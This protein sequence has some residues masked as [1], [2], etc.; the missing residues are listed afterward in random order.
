MRKT[1]SRPTHKAGARRSAHLT[2][3]PLNYD[4]LDR[5]DGQSL[6]CHFCD[7]AR[8]SNI[9]M[10]LVREVARRLEQVLGPGGLPADRALRITRRP[11]RPD[12]RGEHVLLA[13][14]VLTERELG[15]TV[16]QAIESVA[17]RRRVS[18][19]KVRHAYENHR[20]SAELLRFV[21]RRVTDQ[22]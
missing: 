22:P 8:M 14:E 11:G 3:A 5:L 9:D 1:P 4:A 15:A 10:R 2:P 20:R 7:E 6:I 18:E 12:K 17:K 19:S 21:Q 13:R 16:P